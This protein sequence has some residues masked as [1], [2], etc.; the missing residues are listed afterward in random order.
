MLISVPL[1]V[2]LT[3]SWGAAGAPPTAIQ[4]RS[5]GARSTVL[6]KL[7]I[8]VPLGC[9]LRLRR[10]QRRA[11]TPP[12]VGHA[13]VRDGH[14]HGAEVLAVEHHRGRFRGRARRRRADGEGVTDVDPAAHQ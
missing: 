8:G 10:L 13:L 14:P 5:S 9:A 1:M 7:P 11:A 4:S 2:T 3:E 6:V 12:A